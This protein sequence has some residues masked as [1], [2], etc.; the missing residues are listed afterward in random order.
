MPEG[1]MQRLA[2]VAGV[3]WLVVAGYGIREAVIDDDT[4]WQVAYAVFTLAL[5]GGAAC[6]VT[7][8]ALSTGESGRPRLRTAG[9]I[10]GGLGCLLAFVG[11][12]ALAAWMTALGV[13]L[14]MVAGASDPGPRRALTLLA[15]AQLVGVMV[16]IAATEVGVGARDEYGDHP[17]AGGIAVVLVA[18]LTIV[19]LFELARSSGREAVGRRDAGL[20]AGVSRAE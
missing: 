7:A 9:L 1:R 19:G 6:S 20:M 15:A 10:V 5:L 2:L 17:A 18:A 3:A 8:A 12:W 4:S 13:G 14:A 16:F 11:A